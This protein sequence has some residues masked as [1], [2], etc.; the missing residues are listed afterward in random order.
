M[1]GDFEL[2]EPLLVLELAGHVGTLLDDALL[3]G[4]LE[5]GVVLLFG[6]DPAVAD[7]EAGEIPFVTDGPGVLVAVENGF[8]DVGDVLA[9]VGLSGDVELGNWVR[10]NGSGS[11]ECCG[12]YIVMLVLGEQS[13]PPLQKGNKVGSH[14]GQLVDVGVGVDIT[15]ASTDRVV[16][17]QDVGELVPR[18][19]VVYQ[20]VLVLQ[21]VGTNL[22]Q[23]TILGT[24]TGTTVQPDNGS[25]F[26]GYMFVLEVPE[27]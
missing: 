27:E 10:Q 15:E 19:I 12:T 25:L 13:K 14:L 11:S 3:V 2:A 17:K 4:E 21:S 16:D 9:G 26:V 24:A 1:L 22:H 6:G 7:Q 8:G 5:V 23:C 20:S 18:S